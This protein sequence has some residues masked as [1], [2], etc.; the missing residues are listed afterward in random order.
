MGLST[1]LGSGPVALGLPRVPLAPPGRFNLLP[2]PVSVGVCVRCLAPFGCGADSLL[3]ADAG[4][5][6]VAAPSPP[7]SSGT[8]VT[9]APGIG[10]GMASKCGVCCSSISGIDVNC[11]GYLRSI[12]CS[13][14]WLSLRVGA[15]G[16]SGWCSAS[17]V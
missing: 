1:L 14:R 2:E 9:E 4:P 3:F 11:F 8:T 5:G 6:C 17:G 16:G 10:A 15:C 7:A 13:R 12:L